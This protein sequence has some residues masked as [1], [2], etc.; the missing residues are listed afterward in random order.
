M[1][2]K[3]T[4]TNEQQDYTATQF[5]TELFCKAITEFQSKPQS[6]DCEKERNKKNYCKRITERSR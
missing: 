4:D 1:F 6:D 3:H 5:C 2:N